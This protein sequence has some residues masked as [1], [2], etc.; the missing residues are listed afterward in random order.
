M[1]TLATVL[2]YELLVLLTALAGLIAYRMIT[3]QINVTGLLMDKTSGRAI[4]PGRIQMLIVTL[5]IAG[6]YLMMV[7]ENADKGRLPELPNEYLVALGASHGTFLLGKLYGRFATTFGLAS[8][9]V[10]ERAKPKE[11]ENKQ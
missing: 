1:N 11:R 10:R 2:R 7:A 6:Y 9:K 3:Q 5:G 8:P 4:S